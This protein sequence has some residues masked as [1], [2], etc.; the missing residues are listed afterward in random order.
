[1]SAPGEPGDPGD[2]GAGGLSPGAVAQRLGVAVTTLRSWHTRYGL[3]PSGHQSG[4]HRRYTEEDLER[5]QLMVQITGRGVPAARAARMVTADPATAKAIYATGAGAD[6]RD[7]GGRTLPV[8][9]A[10]PAARGLARAASRLDSTTMLTTIAQVIGSD[11][12][13]NTWEQL[14][15]PVLAGITYK[16]GGAEIEVEHLLSRCIT[17]TLIRVPRPVGGRPEVLLTC[18]AEEHHTLPLEALAAALAER[19]I[20]ARLLGARVPWPSLREAVRRTGPQVLVVWAQ[21]RGT[22]DRLQLEKL[23]TDGTVPVVA[24]TGPGWRELPDGVERPDSLAAAVDLVLRVV[25]PQPSQHPAD[26]D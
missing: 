5:L 20:P 4:R 8:G 18:A 24:A 25:R 21:D 2:P 11:G 12:V 3:G 23:L 15:R 16:H 17:E 9:R 6:G 1:M 26:P 19:G 13:V 10:G 7:G 22:A 14:L